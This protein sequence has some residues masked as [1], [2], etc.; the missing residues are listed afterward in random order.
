LNFS[1]V[2]VFTI[3]AILSIATTVTAQAPAP[4]EMPVYTG[5]A[6]GGFAVTGGNTQTNN[7]NLTAALTRDPKTKNVI[8]ATATYL[9]GKQNK[10]LNLDRTGFNI[11]DEYS[12]SKRTFMFGQVDYLRDKFKEIIFL[13]VPGGGVGYKLVNSGSTLLSIDGAAGG[14][15]EKN[16][17]RESSKTGSLTTG[18]RFQQKLSTSATFTESLSTI[19]KTSDFGD[20]LTNFSVGATTT[21]VGNLE[22]KLEFIDSY[23]NKP[24]KASL[25]KNDTAFVTAFVVKF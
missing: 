10:L 21:L 24:A 13:W 2:G 5:N 9:R 12:L 19:W 20:S 7:V 4:S 3:F 6:G 25:K 22:L 8:K 18:Q 11:R 14:L 23:K 1:K 17:G 16:P 15:L